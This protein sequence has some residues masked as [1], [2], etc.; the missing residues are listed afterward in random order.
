[1]ELLAQWAFIL[2][3]PSELL[4][5]NGCSTALAHFTTQKPMVSVFPT[6]EPGGKLGIE[7]TPILS[8][9]EV[10][11]GRENVTYNLMAKVL[12]MVVVTTT[13]NISTGNI[14]VL[15][16]WHLV[17]EMFFFRVLKE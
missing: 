12:M 10:L 7:I 4:V 11:H 3:L 14:H 1:M 8:D 5:K 17:L 2:Q 6:N 13:V 16:F 9:P 15:H